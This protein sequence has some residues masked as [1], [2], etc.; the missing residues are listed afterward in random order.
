MIHK[1]LLPLPPL[2]VAMVVLVAR[3][4]KQTRPRALMQQQVPPTQNSSHLCAMARKSWL[5]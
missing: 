1:L 3:L 2:L 5:A 4:L